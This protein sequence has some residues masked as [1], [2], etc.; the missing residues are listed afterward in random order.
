MDARHFSEVLAHYVARSTYSAPQLSQ[1]SYVPKATLVNWL[2]GRV[3]RPRSLLNVLQT[4]AALRLE[5]AEANAVLRAAMFPALEDL[6]LGSELARAGA[7]IRELIQGWL[8]R[9]APAL[10]GARHQLRA[11]AADFVGRAS[12]VQVLSERIRDVVGA[13]RAAI[14]L[15]TGLGGVGKTELALNV[16]QL[17]A[18]LFPDAQLLLDLRGTTAAPLAPEEALRSVIRA[19]DPDSALPGDL[20]MLE[21]LYRTLL[22]DARVLIVADNAGSADQIR[23]L[24]P[25]PGSLLL[26]TSRTVFH[27]EGMLP[28]LRLGMLDPD[29]A[30]AFVRSLH[31][32]IGTDAALLAALCG[33]LPLALR[34]GAAG[35]ALQPLVPVAQYLAALADERTRL[36]SLRSATDPALDVD[37]SLMLSYRLLEPGAQVVL[38]QLSVFGAP[39]DREA[40]L[41]VVE[42]PPALGGGAD[43]AEHARRV[44]AAANTLYQR[45]LL[46]FD[47]ATQ[48]YSLHDL[49]RVFAAARG[50]S[51]DALV[52][53]YAAHYAAVAE[54]AQTLYG[55]GGRAA[56]EGLALFDRERRHIDRCWRRLLEGDDRAD[57]RRATLLIRFARA[58]V[59][60]GHLR[61]D[62]QSER[63]PLL[64]AAL[65][66]ARQ[67]GRRDVEGTLLHT[68]GTAYVDLGGFAE[69]GSYFEQSLTLLREL[70]DLGGEAQALGSLGW[71]AYMR[72]AMGAALGNYRASLKLARRAGDRRRM[73]YALGSLGWVYRADGN[74]RRALRYYRLSL[75]VMR[76]IDD[77]QGECY[78]LGNLGGG[79]CLTGEVALARV[80]FEQGL[81]LAQALGDQRS[82]GYALGNLGWVASIRGM[83]AEA[84]A[85]HEESLATFQAIGNQ[86]GAG[87]ALRSL[88]DAYG[89]QGRAERATAYAERALAIAR[90]LGDRRFEG[91]VWQSLGLVAWR[92]HERER[93]IELCERA[94]TI[95]RAVGERRHAA[96][97]LTVLGQ[98]YAADGEVRRARSLLAESLELSRAVGDR[99]AEADAAWS[100][101]LL[102]AEHADLPAALPLLQIRIA[103]DRAVEH[104]DAAARLAYVAALQRT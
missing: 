4:I 78:A 99:S 36:A 45:S 5:V 8:S 29:A 38:A 83:V 68:V 30:V 71:V 86:Q 55:Q 67:T 3:G 18:Q 39:F 95:H 98:L 49:V 65:A 2:N 61:Y 72:G 93:A 76:T 17:L 11:P 101:G 43:E 102:L 74:L 88:A 63:L 52:L 15:I 24:I 41:A 97:T 73:S 26:V 94:L 21:R 12:E 33:Y 47:P 84:V 13:R 80:C 90:G 87:Y 64:M 40:L 81:G 58:T 104:V 92:M 62:T 51:G 77:R 89:A 10:L 69:A 100:M 103:F 70:G 37:A 96:E 57:E 82:V 19:F 1:L 25:P 54:A 22:R 60:L 27:V 28:P 9:Y 44:I 32:P 35:L 79:Y 23:P 6:P 46:A 16:A 53:R 14:A 31:P 91:T 59:E 66:V 7:Q 48:R 42:L 75:A 56:Q 50:G 20:V 85:Y 34:V